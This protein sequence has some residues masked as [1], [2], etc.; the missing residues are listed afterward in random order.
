MWDVSQPSIYFAG[1]QTDEM[2]MFHMNTRIS[3]TRQGGIDFSVMRMYMFYFGIL[4]R[5]DLNMATTNT[6]MTTAGKK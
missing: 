1:I 4:S 2:K 6:T 5:F 3:A